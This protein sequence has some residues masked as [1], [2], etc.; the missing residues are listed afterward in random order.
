M[1]PDTF[2]FGLLGGF[3]LSFVSYIE[4]IKNT[5][6]E[7]DT[8]KSDE[9]VQIWEDVVKTFKVKRLLFCV[10]YALIGGIV[11]WI[12]N[13]PSPLLAFYIGMTA[14]PTLSKFATVLFAENKLV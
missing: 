14:Y 11:A 3:L 7:K 10:V 9:N 2:T 13:S 5:Q 1:L 12:L 4:T 6:P 8:E